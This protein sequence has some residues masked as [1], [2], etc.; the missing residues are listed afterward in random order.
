MNYELLS[1]DSLTP[2]LKA[3]RLELHNLLTLKLKSQKNTPPGHLRIEQ[4]NGGRRIQFY[5]CTSTAHPRG[6]YLPVSQAALAE[7][8]AQKDYDVK[9][10][11]LL[12]RQLTVLEKL[13]IISDTKNHRALFKTLSRAA[14]A[15]NTRNSYRLSVHRSLAE[16][17][18]APPH[19][20]RRHSCVHYSPR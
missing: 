2:Q 13:I 19:L 15:Y 14:K 16:Y 7:K 5:H 6:A 17:P 3:R 9:L 20:C 12:Q 11:K 1:P 8:L 10:I 18:V 4:K